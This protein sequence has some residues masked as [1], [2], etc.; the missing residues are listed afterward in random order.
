M[1]A[2]LESGKVFRWEIHIGEGMNE[3]FTTRYHATVLAGT[4]IY[5]VGEITRKFSRHW[6]SWPY[7]FSLDY[8]T[9]IW[10]STSKLPVRLTAGCAYAFLWEDCLYLL[11]SWEQRIDKYDIIL[12]EFLLLEDRVGELRHVGATANFDTDSQR[13][14]MFGG[15]DLNYRQ[16]TLS[17]EIRVWNLERGEWTVPRVSGAPPSPRKRHS[18]CLV[19]RVLYVFGGMIEDWQWSNELFLC[20]NSFQWSNLS[21][22]PGAPLARSG[23]TLTKCGRRLI[24]F[25]GGSNEEL[26]DELNFYEIDSREWYSCSGYE[27]EATF[28]GIILHRRFQTKGHCAIYI[29]KKGLLVLGGPGQRLKDYLCLRSAHGQEENVVYLQKEN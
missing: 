18:S 19:G 11:D 15:E 6:A 17:N 3:E 26:Y 9:N 23:A 25:G 12:D 20:S 28:P 1:S 24:L 10:S 8:T 7:L 29:E 27:L 21:N 4:K 13:L 14:I 2:S 5:V 22:A 16:E